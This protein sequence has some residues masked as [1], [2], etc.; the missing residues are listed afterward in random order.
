MKIEKIIIKNFRVY[1]ER[2]E[3]PFC[4]LN[5]FIG[6][7][8]VGKSTLLEAL[9]IFFNE[10]KGAVKID[11]SDRNIDFSDRNV[12]IGVVLSGFPEEIDLDAGN[13]TN[14]KNGYLLNSDGLLEIKK[15]YKGATMKPDIEIIANHPINGTGKELYL[16]KINELKKI[17]TDN[18]FEC[19]DKT[20]K[21]E[22]RKSI[23]EGCADLQT[24]EIAIPANKEDAKQ[25]WE[26]INQLLPS[27]ALFQS[28]RTNKDSDSEVQ[29][30]MKF[31]VQEILKDETLIKKLN[32][33]ADKVR[34]RT[35]QIAQSTLDKLKEMNPEIATE[36][37]PNIPEKEKLK[38]AEVFKNI[39]ISSDNNIP[40]NKR[41]S[42]V[43]RLILL[44]FFRAEA[45]R[46]QTLDG[47]NN[48]IYAIE[49]P[50]TSQHHN[51]QKML[52]EALK[53]LS[54]NNQILLTTHSHEIVN[55]L[56]KET[57]RIIS[58][59]DADKITVKRGEEIINLAL[60]YVSANEINF[61]VFDY[62]S[63]AF[64]TEL[65][66]YIETKKNEIFKEKINKESDVKAGDCEREYYN[67]KT[68][69]FIYISLH[70]YIRHQIHHPE[71]EGNDRFTDEDLK[72]SIEEMR[73]YL[74]NGKGY[75]QS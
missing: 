24:K 64:H 34:E 20:K 23:W 30:P 22:L 10:G 44:N 37:Q 52:A 39:S 7:N 16:K 70:K 49:E 48:I 50:E 54:K 65:Y 5:V 63:E 43:K 4:D 12:E 74:L 18:K 61:L 75:T 45:E 53:I 72:K 3:I 35:T 71:N 19:E 36:L 13:M 1:K 41:G 46:K 27:Y 38:W 58:K 69:K 29:D 17:V 55:L 68:K 25:F 33:V 57:Y 60:N 9:D 73:S 11:S 21:A 47:K 66:S 15:T 26:K 14:I 6:K 59:D 2:V 40:L 67:D 32:E 51:H 62:V 56:P 28:D 31:A 8:D 42:G